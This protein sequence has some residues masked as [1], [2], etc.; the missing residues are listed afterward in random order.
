MQEKA[1]AGH[2]AGDDGKRRERLGPHCCVRR[3]GGCGERS[4][5]REGEAQAEAKRQVGTGAGCT[6]IFCTKF[7]PCT[8]SKR[9][10]SVDFFFPLFVSSSFAFLLSPPPLPQT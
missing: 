3:E 10:S 9:Q 5:E 6:D 4:L 7:V 8:N 1:G 2:R